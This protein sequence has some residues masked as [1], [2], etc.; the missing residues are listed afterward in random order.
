LFAVPKIVCPTC[1]AVLTAPR[2]ALATWPFCS[3]RCRSADLGSWLTDAYRISSPLSEEDLDQ[4]LTAAP[5]DPDKDP[6]S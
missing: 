5:R 4:G 6:P 3:P 2:S 1:K